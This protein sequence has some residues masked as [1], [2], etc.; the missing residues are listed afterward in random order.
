MRW[1]LTADDWAE[2]KELRRLGLPIPTRLSTYF[3]RH[4]DEI[5]ELQMREAVVRLTRDGVPDP[6]IGAQLGATPH[7]VRGWRRR[8]INR[9]IN[10]ARGRRGKAQ[11]MLGLPSG[12]LSGF[13]PG[14]GPGPRASVDPDEIIDSPEAEQLRERCLFLRKSMMPYA[15]M[16]QI[17]AITE[18]EARTYTYEAIEQLEKSERMNA[19]LE[20]RLM[21]EQIDQ[22]IAAIHAPSTGLDIETGS[23]RSVDY[24]A[25]DRMLKLFEKKADLLGLTTPPAIDIRLKLQSLAAEGG[26]DIVDLEEVA[27]EV[28]Q[29][30]K[31]RLPEFR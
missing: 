15:K 29:N 7:E 18:K 11:S 24:R 9:S 13:P 25:I 21:I 16:A 27:R 28:L 14:Y 6:E 12:K 19:D 3:R 5:Y 1:G 30:H 31:I 20:R 10:R 4:A 17:L 23:Y 22:M 26:Y 2:R 8:A